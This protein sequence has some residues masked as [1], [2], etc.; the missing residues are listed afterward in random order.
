MHGARGTGFVSSP[1]W[2]WPRV[3][4]IIITSTRSKSMRPIYVH[5][6]RELA[7]ALDSVT[8]YIDNLTVFATTYPDS[9]SRGNYSRCLIGE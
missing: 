7:S 6:P 1:A 4:D 9:K 5:L 3:L 2:P 8:F